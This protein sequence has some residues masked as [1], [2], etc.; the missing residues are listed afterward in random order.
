MRVLQIGRDDW[1]ASTPLPADV[2]WSFVEADGAAG[3]DA[4]LVG[5]ADVTVVDSRCDL[6]GLTALDAS[7]A[8]HTLLVGRNLAAAFDDTYRTF[9]ARKAAT[10]EDLSDRERL[11]ASLP[12]RFFARQFGQKLQVRKAMLSPFHRADWWYEGSSCL[13]TTVESD[14]MRQLVIWKE[15]IEYRSDRA[16]ELWPE[17]VAD[18]GCEVELGVQLIRS[19]TADGIVSQRRYT[20]AELAE[21]IVVAEPTSGY[22][23]CSLFVKGT[24]TVRVGPLHYRHSRWGSGQFLPG[25]QRIVDSR[26]EELFYYFH[27]GNLKPPLNIYFA[28]YRPAEG[29]EG[30][31]MMAGLGHPFLLVTDPRLEGGRF[32]LGSEELESTLLEVIRSHVDRLGFREQDVILSGLSMGSF[33]ALYYGSQLDAHAIIAGKPIVDLG[34][35]AERGRLVRPHE[36]LTIFDVVNF[37]RHGQ[38]GAT[39]DAFTKELL[40]R[41]SGDPGFGDTRILMAYMEQDDYDDDAYYTLLRSQTGKRTTV[42]ARG[43][44]GRHNDDSASI[45]TWFVNQY[46]RVIAEYG[47]SHDVGQ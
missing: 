44:Q 45:V 23:S 47:R 8:P 36:F 25:G 21:P 14:A 18:P 37:W 2:E 42:I 9:L 6:A 19:G 30:S 3:A 10:Y 15:N 20:Q 32:Y 33:G 17:F 12:R 4:D 41:W 11:A 13:G 16:L 29:F 27:P 43:Y 7:I 5:R 24:G 28:G 38:D 40:A 31:L 46:K 1:S 34:Y 22:L 39:V 26:R 35:V